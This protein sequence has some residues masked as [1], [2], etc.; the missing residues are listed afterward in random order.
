[1]EKASK[2]RSFRQA[3]EALELVRGRFLD[4]LEAKRE[5][6]FHLLLPLGAQRCR[7]QYQHPPDAA[8]AHQIGQDQACLDWLAQAQRTLGTRCSVLRRRIERE[9]ARKREPGFGG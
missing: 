5:L 4:N 6:V 9:F 3:Y 7:R 2:R 1:L 8:L